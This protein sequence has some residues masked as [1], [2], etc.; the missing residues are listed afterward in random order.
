MVNSKIMDLAKELGQEM[1][2]TIEA[3][4][5]AKAREEFM[6]D[7]TAQALFND[8]YALKDELH[9]LMQS[10]NV[11]QEQADD[12]RERL[13]AKE[14]EIQ[15]N[16]VAARLVL[17]ENQ[18]NSYVNQVFNIIAATVTGQDPNG[19]GGGCSCDSCGCGGCH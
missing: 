11:T 9:S 5:L 13:L 15:I 3:E 2:N 17:C 4:D 16:P 8:F 10:E 18:F 19:C 1:L 14:T 12:I 6:Q 7:E